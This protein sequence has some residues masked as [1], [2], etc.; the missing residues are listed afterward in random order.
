MADANLSPETASLEEVISKAVR[1][2]AL[3]LRVAMPCRV[4]RVTGDQTV[5]LQPLYMTRFKGQDAQAMAPLHDVP[6]VMPQGQDF[7]VTYPVAPGDLGLALFCDRNLDAF[8]ASDGTAPQDPQD[9]RCHDVSDAVFFPGLVP[10]KLQTTDVQQTGDM[11]LQNG[12]LTLRLQKSGRLSVHNG[13][14]EVVDLLDQ[15]LKAQM[16]LVT[17]LAQALVL[18]SLGPAP[19][20]M[21]SVQTF[22]DIGT[23]LAA[24]KTNLDTFKS[25]GDA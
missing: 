9:D 14:Q 1:Y 3:N 7:R 25:Q 13:T 18:T 6:V 10:Q 16:D 2:G 20:T 17:D 23:R 15:L 5:D 24:L 21:N 11:V 19:F 12:Q 22:V 8:L 4:V